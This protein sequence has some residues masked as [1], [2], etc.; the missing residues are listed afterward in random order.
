MEHFINNEITKSTNPKIGRYEHMPTKIILNKL[1][2]VSIPMSSSSEDEDSLVKKNLPLSDYTLE[3]NKQKSSFIG[4]ICNVLFAIIVG[5]I[6]LTYLLL[7][8]LAWGI[9]TVTGIGPILHWC[10][11]RSDEALLKRETI[12]LNNSELMVIT[13]PGGINSA[14]GGKSY[15][16]VARWVTPETP[17]SKPPVVLPNGLAATQIFLSRP[18]DILR[19]YGFSS[20]TFD[21]MG[22][23]FSDPN[24]TG[25]APSAVDI[26]K[27][28]D[29]VMRSVSASPE[30]KWIAVGASMGNT[31]C[32]SFMA[33]YPDRFLGLLNLDG[34]PYPY[35]TDS[36]A[37]AVTYAGLYAFMAG[38]MWTGIFRFFN[39]FAFDMWTKNAASNK[40]SASHILAQM[41]RRSF[42]D[43]TV[44]EFKTMM[45]YDGTR[46]SALD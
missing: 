44:L 32:Q 25:L 28:M 29:Y 18:Q 30:T 5:P 43:N 35:L 41:N 10:Y 19:D 2:F 17:S 16:I 3:T 39:S 31:I 15:D 13:I 7:I 14:S 6:F 34:F 46:N 12:L 37:F 27:E 33:L 24:P 11:S 26:C 21:R 36:K 8:L 38:I 40:F 9:L 4:N 22:C 45:R 42:F 20:L 23:G 1:R